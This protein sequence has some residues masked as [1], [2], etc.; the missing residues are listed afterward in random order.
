MI[1][2]SVI[3]IYFLNFKLFLIL[4]EFG[5]VNLWKTIEKG[6]QNI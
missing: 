6:D 4:K 1:N 5:N 3:N 2:L